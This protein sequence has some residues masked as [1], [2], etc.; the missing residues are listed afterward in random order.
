ML[1]HHNKTLF[2]PILTTLSKFLRN[3]TFLSV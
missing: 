3:M 1:H 2:I